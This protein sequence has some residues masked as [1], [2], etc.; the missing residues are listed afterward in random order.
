MNSIFQ[1]GGAEIV[2]RKGIEIGKAIDWDDC[3]VLLQ[4]HDSYVFEI[5]DGTEDY[6]IPK[7]QGIM[8]S[9]SDLSPF[10]KKIPFPVNFKLWGEE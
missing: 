8:E 5:K 7:L 10:F 2:K 4:V 1:G 3:K 9:V 6:W